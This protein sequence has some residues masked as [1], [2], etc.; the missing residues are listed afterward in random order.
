MWGWLKKI[1]G[2]S[3]TIAYG[4]VQ[5]AV[6]GFLNLLE[7]ATD[8]IND[9]SFKDLVNQAAGDIKLASRIL[10]VTGILTIIARYRSLR[11]DLK[12]GDK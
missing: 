5:M 1:C 8:F 4:Y 10:L 6:S 12:G 3:V 9:P 2:R 11:K 7:P